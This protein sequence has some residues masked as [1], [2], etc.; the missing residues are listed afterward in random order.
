MYELLVHLPLGVNFQTKQ[1]WQENAYVHVQSEYQESC[2][3]FTAF[4]LAQQTATSTPTLAASS[5]EAL[6]H[7][8]QN[9]IQNATQHQPHTEVPRV[10]ALGSGHDWHCHSKQAVHLHTALSPTR[11]RV[12]DPVAMS[13][14]LENTQAHR[15]HTARERC[16]LLKLG[17]PD[18]ATE[19]VHFNLVPE[20][21]VII[22]SCYN[23]CMASTYTWKGFSVIWN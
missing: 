12:L 22:L 2:L 23:S 7:K 20:N 6:K 13:Q 17:L 10:G 8:R 3:S 21:Q 19:K 4:K 1:N 5:W 9:C 18:W 15:H 16:I 11:G 14:Y